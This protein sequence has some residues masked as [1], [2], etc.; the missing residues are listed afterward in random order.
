MPYCFEKICPSCG[1]SY[2]GMNGNYEV[3]GV[4]RCSNCIDMSKETRPYFVQHIPPYVDGATKKI[5]TF[6]TMDELLEKLNHLSDGEIYV[7][8]GRHLMTQSIK[9]SFWWVLGSINNYDLSASDIPKANYEIYNDDK[10][11][12]DKKV[13]EWLKEAGEQ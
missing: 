3:D 2:E 13:A 1:G 7:Y 6:N 8:D 10:T 11:V 5:Y 4:V 12:N 9:K